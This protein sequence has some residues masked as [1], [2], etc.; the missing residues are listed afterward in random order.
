MV[1][2]G[3]R[4]RPVRSR[5]RWPIA[6][7]T[8]GAAIALVAGGKAATIEAGPE[9]SRNQTSQERLTLGVMDRFG[10][11]ESRTVLWRGHVEQGLGTGH[12]HHATLTVAKQ[13]NSA[14]EPD[15][16]LLSFTDA[17]GMDDPF[18]SR[19]IRH[20]FVQISETGSET[21]P[22]ICQL[23]RTSFWIRRLVS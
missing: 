7:M 23:Y 1:E 15:R 8:T 9:R 4:G 11:T 22:R 20:A 17:F 2:G 12:E 18:D 19:N 3:L 13:R 5:K 21:A 6:L 16:L 10:E 14:T